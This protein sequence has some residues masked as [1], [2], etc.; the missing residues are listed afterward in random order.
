MPNFKTRDIENK[1]PT[2][3]KLEF[4]NSIDPK[5]TLD[6]EIRRAAL[7]PKVSIFFD[8]IQLSPK[9]VCRFLFSINSDCQ[10]SLS[11]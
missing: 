9:T 10:N 5:E 7:C 4:F 3:E 6:C 11:L 8:V 1:F 2:Q